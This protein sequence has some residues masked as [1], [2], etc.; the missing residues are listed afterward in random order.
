MTHEWHSDFGEPKGGACTEIGQ[1]L[2]HLGLQRRGWRA[3]WQDSH[4]GRVDT[5]LLHPGAGGAVRHGYRAVQPCPVGGRRLHEDSG[6]QQR[7]GIKHRGVPS[8]AQCEAALELRQRLNF[9]KN[10][11]LEPA[12]VARDQLP[13][14]E[15]REGEGG[16]SEQTASPPSPRRGS[17]RSERC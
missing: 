1:G 7:K 16:T 10:L 17:W 15:G 11:G 6:H 13:A 2:R 8:K 5:P 4:V 9:V 12:A 3:Q 14:E